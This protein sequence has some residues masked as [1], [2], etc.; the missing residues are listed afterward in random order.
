MTRRVLILGAT[1]G[2]AQEASRCFAAAHARLFLVARDPEKLKAL[3]DDLKIRG[4]ESVETCEADLTDDSSIPLIISKSVAVWGGLD[5]ALIAHG[6][7]P[8]QMS[9]ENDPALLRNS[10]EVNYVS[11]V[12]LLMQL[13][14]AFEDQRSGVLA[15][16]GSVAGDRGRRSNYVY[17][18]A[19]AALATFVAG[20]RLR[21]ATANVQVVLIKPGWVSTP[22]TAHLPQNFLFASAQQV[23]RGV[24][25]AIISPRPIVYLPWYWKWIMRMIRSLPEPAFAKLNL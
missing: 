4:A 18:S 2:I 15:I 19:K 14:K 23:G 13:G 16:I 11:A 24:Y 21:L 17:G 3:T 10:I 1:S 7:L 25:Q 20:L 6:T 8:D 12:S 9:V 5:A 22:M